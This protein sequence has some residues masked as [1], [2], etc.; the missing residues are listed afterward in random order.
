[1]QS[2][3][4]RAKWSVAVLRVWPGGWDDMLNFSSLIKYTDFS[5]FRMKMVDFEYFC[6]LLYT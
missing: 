1:M 3:Y 2:F 6:T 4:L 5:G